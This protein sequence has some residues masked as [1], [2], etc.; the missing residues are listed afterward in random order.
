MEHL[1]IL[2]ADDSTL[3]RNN[4]RRLLLSNQKCEVFE[5]KDVASTKSQLADRKPDILLLDLKMPGGSGFDV[6]CEL[7]ESTVG[8]VVVVLTNLALDENRTKCFEY[9]VRRFYDKSKEYKQAVEF[10][11]GILEGSIDVEDLWHDGG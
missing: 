2:V 5:S 3:V 9:G 8:P 7:H 11:H 1:S 10:V 4:L 6:L